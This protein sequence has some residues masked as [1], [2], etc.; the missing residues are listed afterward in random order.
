MS[1][2]VALGGNAMLMLG[3]SCYVGYVGYVGDVG[4]E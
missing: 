3:A 4:D 2:V 1:H